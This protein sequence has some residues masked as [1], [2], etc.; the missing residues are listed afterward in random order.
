MTNSSLHCI[1]YVDMKTL[2]YTYLF[3]ILSN[4]QCISGVVFLQ[5][6]LTT[7]FS[8]HFKII[9]YDVLSNFGIG[10]SSAS[11]HARLP[12]RPLFYHP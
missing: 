7:I 3:L 11:S 9:F 5:K 8:I 10:V 2:F 6:A 4:F 1:I 12:P